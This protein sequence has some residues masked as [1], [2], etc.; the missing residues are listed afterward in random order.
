MRR[1]HRIAAF[2][3]AVIMALSVLP[4]SAAYAQEDKPVY[5]AIGDSITNA[6]QPGGSHL[7]DESFVNILANEKG[8]T[9]VNK[10]VDGNTAT[11][12][13]AQI[14]SGDLDEYIK[15][16]EVITITCGGND[17]MNLVYEKMA[18]E[19]NRYYSSKYGT[20]SGDDI[21][22]LLSGGA[23]AQQKQLLLIAALSAIQKLDDPKGYLD[24]F[25]ASVESFIENINKVTSA[26]KTMNPDAEIFLSTQYNPYEHFTKLTSL[27][28]HLNNCAVILRQR[29]IENATAGQYTVADVYTAFLGNTAEYCNADDSQYPTG[30]QIDFH[31]SVAGHAAIAEC[32]GQV[33][34]KAK[35]NSSTEST[36]S[37]PVWGGTTGWESSRGTDTTAETAVTNTQVLL[38]TTGDD[39]RA[40]FAIVMIL[41]ALGITAFVS[42]KKK[43]RA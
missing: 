28:G 20:I 2:T 41:A 22:D 29:V 42:L 38:P 27:S 30:M 36:D 1:N 4:F 35:T 8:Y 32:F 18:L 23:D 26:I 33:V 5:L 37:D 39:T 43:Q 16:A 10:G 9:A 14:E 6:Y 15:S 13:L 25:K 24:E 19:F 34:P 12:I 17:L 11:G 21:I 31:P 7:T 3:A 40:A